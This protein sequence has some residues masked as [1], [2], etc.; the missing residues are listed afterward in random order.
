VLISATCG[1]A[2]LVSHGENGFVFN[3]ND[4]NE[5]ATL[6]T[7]LTKEE[8]RLEEMGRTS[9]RLIASWSPFR[10]AHGLAAAMEIGQRHLSTRRRQLLPNPA[11]WFCCAPDTFPGSCHPAEGAFRRRSLD[12]R[13]RSVASGSTLGCR[14]SRT[15]PLQP[16]TRA[17]YRMKS[18]AP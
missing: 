6:M 14:A 13:L 9:R 18:F 2:V 1:S 7:K 4:A 3:P 12:W 10:F 8:A 5:L 11:L 17:A 16:P 15:G